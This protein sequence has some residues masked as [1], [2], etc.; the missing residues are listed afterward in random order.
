MRGGAKQ[1]TFSQKKSSRVSGM[2][3]PDRGKKKTKAREGAAQR[4]LAA[5]EQSRWRNSDQ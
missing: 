5:Q 3:R 4:C 2:V 1:N